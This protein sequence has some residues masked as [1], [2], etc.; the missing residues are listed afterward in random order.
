MRIEVFSSKTEHSTCISFWIYTDFS[1][2]CSSLNQNSYFWYDT[3]NDKIR[4]IQTAMAYEKIMARKEI[5][6]ISLTDLPKKVLQQWLSGDPKKEGFFLTPYALA[7]QFNY[8]GY[9]IT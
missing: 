9:K 1:N 8:S 7:T 2:L 6:P 4:S 5:L 3:Q